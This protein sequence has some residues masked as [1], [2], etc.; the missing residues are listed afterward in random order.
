MFIAPV[1]RLQKEVL[2]HLPPAVMLPCIPLRLSSHSIHMN[3]GSHNLH[4]SKCFE[5]VGVDHRAWR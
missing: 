2:S 1:L 3:V 5:L 4:S